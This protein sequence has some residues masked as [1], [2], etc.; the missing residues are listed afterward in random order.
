MLSNGARCELGR[1]GRF[2]H[3]FEFSPVC[4]FK[5]VL[6]Q[7]EPFE[8]QLFHNGAEPGTCVTVLGVSWAGLE[9]FT[10]LCL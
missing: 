9:D 7:S 4:V 1:V 10:T 8:D 5:C 2:Y 6:K 3:W